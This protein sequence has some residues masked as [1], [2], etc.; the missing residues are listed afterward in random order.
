MW[1]TEQQ[2]KQFLHLYHPHPHPLVYPQAGRPWS[3]S[4]GY[5]GFCPISDEIPK[6][7]IPDPD[8]TEIYLNVN[9][10]ERQR[11]NTNDMIFDARTIISYVSNIFT[12][13]PGDVIISG[14]KG[15][16][17]YHQCSF[18]RELTASRLWWC[19]YVNQ[20]RHME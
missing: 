2:L 19:F 7:K 1:W 14:M 5:D 16:I 18:L 12:L 13:E 20:G 6:D 3:V 9:G 11:G 4:K 15:G 17:S 8:N 10:V